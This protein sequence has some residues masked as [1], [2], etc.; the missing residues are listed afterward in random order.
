GVLGSLVFG[1]AILIW[2]AFFS[3]APRAERFG[4]VALLLII[5]LIT[6]R[7]NDKSIATGAMGMIFPIILTP[8]LSLAFVL[9][10]VIT[11]NLSQG[12]RRA[13]M[14]AAILLACGGFTLLRTNGITAEAGSD[15][16][17]RW[18]KTSEE[19]LLAQAAAEPAPIPAA[20]PAT[21]PAT[22]VS[23]PA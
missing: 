6:S 15:L 21:L 13:T 1:L 20:A 18:S 4:A 17:F 14:V 10:A 16:A 22:P 12:L 8:I 9:W 23:A 19:R 3:R 7:L 11:R 2:W 5:P